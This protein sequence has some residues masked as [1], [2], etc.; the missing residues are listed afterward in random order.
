MS[1]YHS[2]LKV[3]SHS[4][5]LRL[6]QDASFGHLGFHWKGKMVILPTNIHFQDA[7]SSTEETQM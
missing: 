4:D 5:C 2:H 3:L 6:L 1:I 7:P